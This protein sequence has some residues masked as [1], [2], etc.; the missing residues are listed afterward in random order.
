MPFVGV[1]RAVNAVQPHYNDVVDRLHDRV[2]CYGGSGRVGRV[3]MLMKYS[4]FLKNDKYHGIFLYCKY[5]HCHMTTSYLNHH[6]HIG[7]KRA[8][9]ISPHNRHTLYIYNIMRRMNQQDRDHIHND[10]RLHD[11]LGLIVS[12]RR[13]P[14]CCT[15]CNTSCG[16]GS[17]SSS[18]SRHSQGCARGNP[19]ARCNIFNCGLCSSSK[20]AGSYS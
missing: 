14:S 4:Y 8:A 9:A 5:V 10:H 1:V 15:D 6:G 7:P 20:R 2:H 12:T 18:C 13:S 11:K 19:T 17:S 3:R 16:A